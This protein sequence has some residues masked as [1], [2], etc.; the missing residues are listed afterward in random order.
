MLFPVHICVPLPPDMPAHIAD[1]LRLE[2]QQAAHRLQRDG[3]LV[4]LWRVV[5]RQENYSVYEAADGDRL[6]AALTSLPLYPWM[7]VTVTP[8]AQHPNAYAP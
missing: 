3:T 8:L 5:G 4:H 2:E 6:H 7:T 1:Q